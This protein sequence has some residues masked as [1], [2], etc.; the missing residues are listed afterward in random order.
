MSTLFVV[1]D[2]L[3]DFPGFLE[4]FGIDLSGVNGQ[5]FGFLAGN[6]LAQLE[7]DLVVE[8]FN[9][10]Q[11]F[12]L[13]TVRERI[14]SECQYWGVMALLFD[15]ICGCPRLSPTHFIGHGFHSCFLPGRYR[16]Y[17]GSETCSTGCSTCSVA[18]P[19]CG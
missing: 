7:L 19:R 5:G 14:L 10:F 12:G 11:V 1:P 18:P 9:S 15:L 16:C 4:L 3:G 2:N 6:D 8:R 13:V 17:D